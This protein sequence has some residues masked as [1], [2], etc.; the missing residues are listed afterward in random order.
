M[1]KFDWNPYIRNMLGHANLDGVFLVSS[2]CNIS[3]GC[4]V[5]IKLATDSPTFSV[6]LDVLEINLRVFGI[7]EMLEIRSPNISC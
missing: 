3:N 4:D 5:D 2:C 6:I 1:R 7:L